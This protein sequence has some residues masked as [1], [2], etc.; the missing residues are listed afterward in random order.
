VFLPSRSNDP[1]TGTGHRSPHDPVAMRDLRHLLAAME[2]P[3]PS[4][5]EHLWHGVIAAAA[6]FSAGGFG[7]GSRR[8]APACCPA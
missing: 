7:T 1:W 2:Q 3:R 5:L 6:G 8:Q 4:P